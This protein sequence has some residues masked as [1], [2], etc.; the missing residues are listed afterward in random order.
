MSTIKIKRSG[1]SSET[2]SSLEHGELALNY[3]DGKLFYKDATD[4]ITELSTGG[5]A[6]GG[7]DSAGVQGIVDDNITGGI[8]SVQIGPSTSVANALQQ[9]VIGPSASSTGQYNVAI[10]RNAS[11]QSS[12]TAATAVGNGAR[13]G[14]SQGGNNGVAVGTNAVVEKNA[15]TA[16]GPNAYVKNGDNATAV[17][18]QANAWGTSALALGHGASAT[19]TE[20]IAIGTNTSSSQA[21]TIAMGTSSVASGSRSVAI[22][23]GTDATGGSSVALGNSAQALATNAIAIGVSADTNVNAD[24]IAIG[25]NTEVSGSQGISIG[26]SAAASQASVAIGS[27]ASVTT[28]TES[29]AIGPFAGA[30]GNASLALGRGAKANA[31][32][33]IALAAT[34]ATSTVA[35][36]YGID[37]RTSDSGS[38]TYSTDSDWVFGAPVTSSEFKF[39]DG[40]SM[41]TAP[42]GGG[43]GGG[44]DS[45]AVL[46]TVGID[47]SSISLGALADPSSF[48]NNIAI[49]HKSRASG[50]GGTGQTIAIGFNARTSSNLSTAIGANAYAKNQSCT[51][52]G[53][54]TEADGQQSTAI[55]SSCSS[56]AYSFAAGRNSIAAGQSSVAIGDTA[57]ANGQAGVVIGHSAGAGASVSNAYAVCIGTNAGKK[58]YGQSAILIG[59]D[60]GYANL[61]SSVGVSSIAIG[62]EAGVGSGE[63]TISIGEK[64][65]YYNTQGNY[66]SHAI[67]M[68]ASGQSGQVT[69]LFKH[70]AIDIRTNDSDGHMWF[71][72]DSDWNFGATVNVNGD[73]NASGDITA[74]STSVS[75]DPRLKTDIVKIDN[76]VEKVQQLNGVSWDWTRG[77]KSAGVLSTDVAAVLPEAV[78]TGKIFGEDTEY[79]KVNYNAL[80]GLLVEAVKDLQS[81]V[82]EL[83]AGE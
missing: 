6:G 64:A 22:G 55:G 11:V 12:R 59:K 2:P 35:T 76:A 3:A 5:G 23:N 24:G 9:T 49:G 77:G 65:G 15:G 46:A 79:D 18:M 58:G 20:A 42:T 78:T 40:T 21:D 43:A 16:I 26:L 67:F 71:S 36:Q 39:S 60:A 53:I 7:L 70:Y 66:A 37:I 52:I 54:G 83:K 45:A 63:N 51:A 62:E 33:T 50:A 17:G 82:D 14:S 38:V 61:A 4:T 27:N 56:E 10:G 73:V 81:Q 34:G 30:T 8:V 75:S 28:G 80:I 19:S 31:N 29:T 57:R 1:T 72:K 41:T 44:L 68:N 25:S 74:F 13:V 48:T 32:N 69:E 47:S